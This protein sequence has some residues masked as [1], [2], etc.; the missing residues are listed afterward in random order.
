MR[1]SFFAL[2]SCLAL[3]ASGGALPADNLQRGVP[4]D[5]V[6][7]CPAIV[8]KADF[9]VNK[10]RPFTVPTG[11]MIACRYPTRTIDCEC[12]SDF[13]HVIGNV[14]SPS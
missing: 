14:C 8:C 11:P 1:F 4:F 13:S 10:P 6:I 9:H 2:L 5:D 3:L 7:V 12:K